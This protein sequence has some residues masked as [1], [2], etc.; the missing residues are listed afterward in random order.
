MTRKLDHAVARLADRMIRVSSTADDDG[1]CV[2][3]KAP[4]DKP[5]IKRRRQAQA[6]GDWEVRGLWSVFENW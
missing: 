5:D 4:P 3:H 2:E 1:Q 6:D